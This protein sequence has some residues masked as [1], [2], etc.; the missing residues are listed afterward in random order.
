MPRAAM[1]RRT[2][3]DRV[4]DCDIAKPAPSL[5]GAL[6][7]PRSL[8]R[9]ETAGAAVVRDGDGEG[10][11]AFRVELREGEPM[12]LPGPDSPAAV[13]PVCFANL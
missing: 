4:R 9:A 13:L 10:S 8:S 2:A 3:A 1:P 6:V 11:I 7:T 5:P 12:P